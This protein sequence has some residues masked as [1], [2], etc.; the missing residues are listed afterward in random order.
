MHGQSLN[1]AIFA[2]KHEHKAA[3]RQLFDLALNMF[4]PHAYTSPSVEPLL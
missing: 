4:V 3:Y 1:T 2:L